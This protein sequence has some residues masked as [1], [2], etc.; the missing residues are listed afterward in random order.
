[1]SKVTV[2][3]SPSEFSRLDAY[4]DE[5]GFKKSTLIARLIR[6]YLDVQHFP[7]QETLPLDSG[8]ST[9]AKQARTRQGG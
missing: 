1:M 8:L 9:A 4:C 2:L 6:E 5:N 3:L 7:R